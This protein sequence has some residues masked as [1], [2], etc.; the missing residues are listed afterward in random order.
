M[1]NK[2]AKEHYYRPDQR[3][4]QDTQHSICLQKK[5][6]AHEIVREPVKSICD[7]QNSNTTSNREE[8]LTFTYCTCTVGPQ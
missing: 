2:G 8:L 5:Q 6:K 7:W 4:F 1:S 3:H